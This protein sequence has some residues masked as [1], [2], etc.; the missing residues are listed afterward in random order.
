MK[1]CGSEEE[2]FSEI[3][4]PSILCWH[5]ME[6]LDTTLIPKTALLYGNYKFNFYRILSYYRYQL[7]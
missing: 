3:L 4:L 7:R 6:C 2:K 1:I 5:L